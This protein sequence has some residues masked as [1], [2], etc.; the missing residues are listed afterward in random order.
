MHDVLAEVLTLLQL[1]GSVYCQSEIHKSDWAL[2]FQHT[3]G[4]VFHIVGEGTCYLI[5][6]DHEIRLQQGDLLILP[7]GTPHQIADKPHAPCCAD[8][9]LNQQVQAC[10]MM[11]WGDSHPKTTLICGVFTFHPFHR[12][13]IVSLLPTI[14]YFS[15]SLNAQYGLS[16][17]IDALLDE[18]N[19][20]RHG[21][22]LLLHRLA[23][24]LF[25][26]VMRAWLADPHNETH[27]WLGGLRDP[28]IT[29]AL[30]A[31]HAHPDL[32]WTVEK[33]ATRAMMSR[34][35]F[36]AK[37]TDLIGVPPLTYVTRW[38]MQLATEMLKDERIS[39]VQ[40]A[41]K[42]GYMSDI[43]FA[44]AFKREFGYTPAM[45]RRNIPNKSQY[46]DD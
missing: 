43:A 2:Q 38:R 24:I 35:A 9:D 4:A 22:N 16:R 44:K 3:Q 37:F 33:L 17:I 23:D 42:I 15:A 10:L 30:S 18:A 6:D 7:H 19:G 21:K 20:N 8:I 27:G 39:V 13:A 5:T 32:D 36:S 31:I 11:R 29:Q 26:Q 14:M 46:P 34:S 25:V 1:K 12:H 45:Y 28:Q 41:E 40:I